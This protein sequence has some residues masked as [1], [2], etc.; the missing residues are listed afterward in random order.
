MERCAERDREREEETPHRETVRRAPG[1]SQRAI[2]GPIGESCGSKRINPEAFVAAPLFVSGLQTAAGERTRTT[3]LFHAVYQASHP[4][5]NAFHGDCSPAF[6][7]EPPPDVAGQYQQL[8]K[9]NSYNIKILSRLPV[10]AEFLQSTG[11][12]WCSCFLTVLISF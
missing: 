6:K 7:P 5:S 8:H 2:S 12:P 9:W 3:A 1:S 11:S 10:N 4:G